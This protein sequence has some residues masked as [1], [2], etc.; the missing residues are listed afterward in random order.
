MREWRKKKY[1]KWAQTGQIIW[2]WAAWQ[3][4]GMSELWREWKT[5]CKSVC[6]CVCVGGGKG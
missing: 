3:T 5:A 2:W 4:V 1:L 6:E